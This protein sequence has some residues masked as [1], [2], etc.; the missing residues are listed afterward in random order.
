VIRPLRHDDFPELA[1]LWRDLRPDGV[2]SER[3]LRH[4]V[5]SFPQRAE[6]AFW[7][8]EDD[9]VVAWAMAHRRWWRATNSAYIWIG[10]LSRARGRGVGGRLYELTLD[11]VAAIGADRVQSEVVGDEAGERFLAERGFAPTR[12]IVISALDPRRV[13]GARLEERRRRAEAQG[14]RVLPYAALDLERLHRL[15]VETS[16]DEPGDTEPRVRPFEEWRREL[17]EQPDFTNEGSFVVVAGDEPV[18]Y[19]ALAVDAES[20]RGRNEG[21][22]TARAH[23]G[24]G[25][26][27]LAKLAQVRWAAEHGVERV[28]TDNDAQNAPML[29]INAR[30]GYE[31]FVERRVFVKGV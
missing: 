7:V 17:L 14:Y 16:D 30:L 1:R 19:S 18:A 20:R 11:H 10:V 12:T 21:T 13:S 31:P 28:I 9:G 15:D 27:T 5:E 22:G 8:A 24:R 4:L 26:A 2:H 6:G 29:A 3:G 23:R 25:L